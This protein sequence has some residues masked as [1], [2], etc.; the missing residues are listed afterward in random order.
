[1]S[2]CPLVLELTATAAG[3]L[4]VALANLDA[5]LSDHVHC[6]RK[7]AQS[8]LSLIRQYPQRA[9]IVAA[10]TRLA[11]EETSHVV[12]VSAALNQRGQALAY[13]Q[14]D[15][16]ARE[17][18]QQVRKEEP[19]RLLDTLLVFALI[20]ARSAERL[21]LLAQ[22][23]ADQ[24]SLAAIYAALTNAEYRHRDTFLTLAADT[25]PRAVAQARLDELVAVE[26]ELIRRLPA[27]PR[28]H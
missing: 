12:Q 18:R 25:A 4:P 1:M 6:E 3:W 15:D 24:P 26:G 13:D 8:A 7:A 9:D 19:G 27:R 10:A 21:G 22:A 11:H 14:G 5:V 17:L 16:Y 2:C 20:E 28:I 23:L